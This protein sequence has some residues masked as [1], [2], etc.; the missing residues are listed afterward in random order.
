MTREGYCEDC[1]HAQW[2]HNGSGHGYDKTSH[3]TA[4]DLCHCKAYKGA[5]K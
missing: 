2:A 5:D 3:P 1:K 4:C